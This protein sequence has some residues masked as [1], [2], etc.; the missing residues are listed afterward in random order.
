MRRLIE[1]WRARRAPW[2]VVVSDADS[3]PIAT[4]AGSRPASLRFAGEFYA[5]LAVF[6]EG[7]PTHLILRHAGHDVP[8]LHFTCMD[9]DAFQVGRE[10][11]FRIEIAPQ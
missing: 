9:P 7:T 4:A 1:W 10:V 2:V 8:V 3:K 11:E 5:R 6:E